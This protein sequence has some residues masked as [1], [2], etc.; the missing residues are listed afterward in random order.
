MNR[1]TDRPVDDQQ[2]AIEPD[3]LRDLDV[4]DRTATNIKGQGGTLTR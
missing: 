2:L 4:D 1:L 3:T